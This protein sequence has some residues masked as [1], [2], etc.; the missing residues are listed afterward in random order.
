MSFKL[1][2]QFKLGKKFCFSMV[3]TIGKQKKMAAI[4]FLDHLKTKFQNA[5]YS[6]V[7]GIQ[8]PTVWL[9]RAWNF[10]SLYDCV[11]YFDQQIGATLTIP[12]YKSLF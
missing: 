4:L 6:N 1:K 2:K 3:R 11:V 5:Y 8:A 10:F 7:S 12:C 9:K